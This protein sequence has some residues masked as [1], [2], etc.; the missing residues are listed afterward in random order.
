MRKVPLLLRRS[1]TGRT[2]WRIET[3]SR[4]AAAVTTTAPKKTSRS[5]QMLLRMARSPDQIRLTITR[6]ITKGTRRLMSSM[7]NCTR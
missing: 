6:K 4:N 1:V 5:C 3:D 2:L 7:R